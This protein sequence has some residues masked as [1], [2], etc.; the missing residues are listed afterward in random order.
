MMQIYLQLMQHQEGNEMFNRGLGMLMSAYARPWNRGAIQNQWSGMTPDAG[1]TMNNIMKLQQWQQQQQRLAGL[2][3]SVPGLVKAFRL[4]PA[5]IPVL[6]NNPSLIDGVIQA[7]QPDGIYKNWTLARDDYVSKNSD[8]NDPQSVAKAGNDF[9][10]KTPLINALTP[11]GGD[12][13]LNQLNLEKNAWQAGHPGEPLPDD[14][15][16]NSPEDLKSYKNRVN[17]LSNGQNAASAT[18]PGLNFA[19]GRMRTAANT[20]LQH[21]DDLQNV[22]DRAP[23]ILSAARTAG[24]VVDK[25]PP[26]LGGVTQDQLNLLHDIDDLTNSDTAAL[27]TA[28]PHLLSS[29]TPIE[30][31]LGSLKKFDIGADNYTGKLKSLVDGIDTANAQAI[32]ASGQ[33]DQA[34]TFRTP[35]PGRASRARSMTVTCRA[36]GTTSASRR[37]CP[38][39]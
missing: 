19:L 9:E 25:L 13:E 32:G 38:K 21:P 11:A 16:F 17:N 1:D 26:G 4:D 12:P 36:A 37:S 15:R 24:W 6:Q 39:I 35:T 31:D 29:F 18:L 22:L 20:L 23:N 30:A 33:L 27:K 34:P 3:Q 10:Q 14:G 8:P 28:N 2:Q 5:M 7:H